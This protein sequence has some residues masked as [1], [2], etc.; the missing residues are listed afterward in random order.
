[1]KNWIF[2]FFLRKFSFRS[3]VKLE[4]LRKSIFVIVSFGWS[5]LTHTHTIPSNSDLLRWVCSVCS[6]LTTEN[7]VLRIILVWWFLQRNDKS[8]ARF[9]CK[10]ILIF[11]YISNWRIFAPHSMWAQKKNKNDIHTCEM[12]GKY[13][14]FFSRDSQLPL[15]LVFE[16]TIWSGYTLM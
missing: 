4:I 11:Y 16:C 9:R 5:E 14:V 13:A 6:V 15:I 12:N 3:I 7:S 8:N 10:W 2:Y 1:M